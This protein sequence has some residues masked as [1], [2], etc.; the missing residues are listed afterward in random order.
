MSIL[1]RKS[2][3]GQ[4]WKGHFEKMA[5]LKRK[6]WKRAVLENEQ[7]EQWQIWKEPNWI[8]KFW[9]GKT[10]KMTILKRNNLEKDRSEKNN[11]NE[12]QSEQGQFWKG[13]TGKKVTSEKEA[14][15][16]LQLWKGSIRKRT[17]LK[18]KALKKDSSGKDKQIN[19][20]KDKTE[21]GQCRKGIN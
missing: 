7:T 18:R 17:T 14:I 1:K 9:N 12:E 21:K 2:E 3:K 20:E 4:I 15:G 11:L 19:Y 13:T 8:G 6:N 5:I 10:Y 16:N